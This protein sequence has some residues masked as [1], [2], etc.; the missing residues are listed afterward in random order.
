M[1]IYALICERSFLCVFM[2]AYV[3]IIILLTNH[4]IE[5]KKEKIVL[6]S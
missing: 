1:N 4:F 6:S 5:R 2:Y 3:H